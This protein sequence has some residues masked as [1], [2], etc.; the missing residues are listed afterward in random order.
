MT[1]KNTEIIQ[2]MMR[3]MNRVIAKT[4]PRPISKLA[5]EEEDCATA[6]SC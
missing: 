2:T 6:S 1:V 3:N 4:Y 5:N